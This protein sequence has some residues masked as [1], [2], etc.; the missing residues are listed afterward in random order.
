MKKHIRYILTLVFIISGMVM[1]CIAQEGFEATHRFS[2]PGQ[3]SK[4]TTW[5]YWQKIGTIHMEGPMNEADIRFLLQWTTKAKL[6][7]IDMKKV[8]G[9]KELKKGLFSQ[10]RNIGEND[11]LKLRELILPDET[12]IIGDSTFYG[13]KSLKSIKFGEKTVSIGINAFENCTGLD[14]YMDFPK[15]VK[16][17][18]KG[19]FKGCTKLEGFI[20]PPEITRIEEEVCYNCSNLHH[21]GLDEKVD[22]I[23]LEAFYFCPLFKVECRAVKPPHSVSHSFAWAMNGLTVIVP[24]KSVDAYDKAKWWMY[25]HIVGHDEYYSDFLRKNK[26]GQ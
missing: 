17:I 18:G 13:L 24:D 2:Y 4:D 21:V 5:N 6:R 8:R 20:F 11:S 1:N 19:A 15:S 16:K 3:L 10:I 9:F 12:T 25:H 23:A 26:G 22:T 14:F 7:V